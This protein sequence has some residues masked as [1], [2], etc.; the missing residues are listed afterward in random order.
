MKK[1]KPKREKDLIDRKGLLIRLER[2]LNFTNTLGNY[3]RYMG[4]ARAI[5]IVKG[6]KH[7][8]HP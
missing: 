3:H 2:A 7:E 6:M 5:R 1:A 8:P 4:I